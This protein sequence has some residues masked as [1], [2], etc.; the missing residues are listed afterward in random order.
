MRDQIPKALKAY[1]SLGVDLAHRG[2]GRDWSADCPFC[3]HV[4][5]GGKS[6]YFYVNP[7]NGLF[8][9]KAC[10]E[11][12]NVVSFLPK[13]VERAV[14]DTSTAQLRA[15]SRERGIPLGVLRDAGLCWFGDAWLLPARDADGKVRDLRRYDGKRLMSTAECKV[16]LWGLDK[17]ARAREGTQVYLREGEW[18]GLATRWMLREVGDEDSVV[19]AVP[20]ANTLK[21]EWVPYFRGMHVQTGY[22]ND[23]AGDKGQLKSEKLRLVA[24]SLR[25][26]CWPGEG[27]AE[28]YDVRDHA[29]AVVPVR[30]AQ[31]ALDELKALESDRTRVRAAPDGTTAVEVQPSKWKDEDL[32]DMDFPGLVDAFSEFLVMSPDVA[33]A[34]KLMLAVCLSNDIDDDPLWLYVIAPPS[35]GKT[36]LLAQFQESRRCVFVSSVTPHGLVS[37]WRGEGE[38]DPSLIPKL[39]GKTLVA[40]DF[41]EILSMPDFAQNELFSILRGA[42]DG[43]VDK[44]Y[45]NGVLRKYRDCHFSIIA[46]STQAIRLK[47]NAAMGERFLQF[48]MGVVSE[49]EELD[50][51]L[52]SLDNIGRRKDKN[53]SLQKA[54]CAF[55]KKRLNPESL[56]KIPNALKLEIV[57]LARLASMLRAEVARNKYTNDVEIKMDR[58]SATRLTKQLGKLAVILAFIGDRDTVGREDVADAARVALN[59]VGGFGLDM[60]E[61]LMLIGGRGTKKDMS[62]HT[63][64]PLSTVTRRVDDL[65]YTGIMETEPDK[66]TTDRGGKP[67]TIYRVCGG[68]ARLWKAAKGDDAWHREEQRVEGTSSS[69]STRRSERH[70]PSGSGSPRS[71]RV[72]RRRS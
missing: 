48:E 28:G 7:D 11:S 4:G 35:S 29:K 18:D 64:L 56:P 2:G 65:V 43:F 46:G 71:R 27:L 62:E 19:V 67:A 38:K 63:G 14:K 34:L 25:H 42:Y 52:R 22:D 5:E 61:A 16:Q 23:E 51:C 70:S 13:L 53:D 24:A 69:S 66:T 39:R 59:T 47:K 36:E 21:D 6:K 15:L 55:L 30:G 32:P 41:T 26:V 45:G 31:A 40:K 3:A 57:G 49:A 54:V 12:G 37:G 60:V 50:R 33:L 20:G 68:V 58:E 10:G 17:L 72:V 9:C 44:Q 8:D 1:V